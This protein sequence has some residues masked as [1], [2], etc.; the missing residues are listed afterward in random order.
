LDFGVKEN[1]SAFYRVCTG[2]FAP[3]RSLPFGV[4]EG[5]LASFLKGKEQGCL[6][7]PVPFHKKG[8]IK[9]GEH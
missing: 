9:G 3:F 5:V 4:E 1:W 8:T 7:L 6:L 2:L